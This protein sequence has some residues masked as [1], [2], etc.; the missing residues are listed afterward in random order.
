[1]PPPRPPD[2]Y[3][4]PL[5]FDPEDN[6]LSIQNP[7]LKWKMPDGAK[8]DLGGL[9]LKQEMINVA[10]DQVARDKAPVRFNQQKSP[11][12]TTFS[13]QWPTELARTGTVSVEALDGS[14]VWK[15]DYSESARNEWKS[16]LDFMTPEMKAKHVDSS[17]GQAD[18]SREEFEFL[19]KGGKFRMCF[20]Q[21]TSTLESLRI[22]SKP[23]LSKSKGDRI[24]IFSSK[25]QKPEKANLSLAEQNLGNE[26]I[27]NL[28]PS[29]L[30]PIKVTFQDASFIEIASQPGDPQ[31]LDAIESPDRRE[32]ILTGIGTKPSGVTARIL[33]R[34]ITHFWA[35]TGFPQERVWQVALPKESP[36]LRIV[37]AFNIPFTLLFTYDRLP[38]EADR[39]F[40]RGTRSSGTYSA[41]PIIKGYTPLGA[42]IGSHESAAYKMSTNQFEWK[43]AAPNK[44]AE[45][46][47]RLLVQNPETPRPWI[48]H[49]RMF[50]TYPDEVSARLTGILSSDLAFIMLGELSAG[51]WLESLAFTQNEYF[52]KQR[53]GLAARY[54]K[55]LTSIQS[56]TGVAVTDYASLNADLKYNILPGIWN[57]DEIVGLTFGYQQTTLVGYSISVL[58]AGAYWA[59]TMPRIFNDLFNLL[60][61]MNYP[62]YTDMEFIY[63]PMNIGGT[64][65]TGNAYALNFHGKVFWSQRVFGEAGFGVRHVNISGPSQARPGRIAT[66]D[67]S[68]AYGTVGLGVVF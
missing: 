64:L 10:F 47:A 5:R 63:Y 58:G 36:T 43:F 1:M 16:I 53:W 32:V 50:R 52:S 59:R 56:S 28:P 7:Q 67:F 11:Y 27:L 23:F 42:K 2:A 61:F 3:S 18:I 45:N 26:G 13:F 49:Y 34:P 37:G 20:G 30:V 60:P 51:M 4:E 68:A 65:A 54:F 6:G 62:K 39:V 22:C 44:G 9:I 21:T 35:P 29:K 48:A 33:K 66:I 17:W 19:Y 15:R 38:R 31:L 41:Y 55:S 24:K 8:I 12:V 14:V 25:L 57:R 46:R 40:I